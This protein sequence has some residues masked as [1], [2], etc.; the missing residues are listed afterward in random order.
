MQLDE[1]AVSEALASLRHRG[2]VTSLSGAGHRVEKY[3]HRLGR[4]VELGTPRTIDPGRAD[5]ARGANG[6]VSYGAG[7]SACMSS[8][9]WTKSRACWKHLAAHEPKLAASTGA[10]TVDSR[11]A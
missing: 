4:D 6:G 3:G 2:M 9:I 1:A 5:V 8:P 7:R 10:R 11:V